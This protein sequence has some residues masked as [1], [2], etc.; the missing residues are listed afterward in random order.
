MAP[1]SSLHTRSPQDG[2]T[3]HQGEGLKPNTLTCMHATPLPHGKGGRGHKDHGGEQLKRE[4][5]GR[6]TK[7]P[8]GE[9]GAQRK[10]KDGGWS[11]KT[12]QKIVN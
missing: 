5:V 6:E 3:Q 2:Y 4:A 9:S 1:L 8:G 12:E 7:A 11:L 10:K